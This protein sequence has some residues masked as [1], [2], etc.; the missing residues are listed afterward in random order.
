VQTQKIRVAI[1]QDTAVKLHSLNDAVASQPDMELLPIKNPLSSAW[2]QV[3]VDS[4]NVTVLYCT[5][6]SSGEL[7]A[8][9]KLLHSTLSKVL[10]V[11][12]EHI[13][14]RD[15]RLAVFKLP[16]GEPTILRTDWTAV[17]EM[18]RTIVPENPAG[19]PRP[20]QPLNII[21]NPQISA[22]TLNTHI[23]AMGASTGGTEA[24]A[25][26]LSLLPVTM[27][28]IVI[29][30]H[31][32]ANFTRLFAERLDGELPFKVVEARSNVPILPG[33][34]HVAPGDRHLR[35]QAIGGLLHTVLGSSEKVGGHCP[36]V[37]VLFESVTKSA[38]RNAVGVILTGMDADGA[39]GLLSMRNSGAYTLGQDEASSVVYGMPRRAYEKSAPQR[40]GPPWLISRASSSA[41]SRACH[42]RRQH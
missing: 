12:K 18:I 6:F 40:A 36:S 10:L 13:L 27:P 37:D 30:Q 38:G 7:E 17:L 42:N 5:S 11:T 15:D 24:L 34:I 28:G 33:T 39:A 19:L 29:V 41:I 1:C 14:L 21:Q 25:T 23:I 35:V 9:K 31:M 20:L 26:M 3:I 4:P 2:L 16:A 22:H 32:P 8:V